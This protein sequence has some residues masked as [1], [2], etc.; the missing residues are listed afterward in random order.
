MQSPPVQDVTELLS[1]VQ[2]G[3][4]AAADVLMP[5]VY[6]ELRRLAQREL[7]A[8]LPGNTLQATALVHEAYLRLVDQ[9]RAVFRGRAQFFSIASMM[10]RR[11]LIDHARARRAQKRGGDAERITLHELSDLINPGATERIDLLALDE[12]M[13]ELAGLNHRQSRVVE[14]KFYGGMSIDEIAEVLD[15]SPRTV[16]D[17]WRFARAWLRSRLSELPPP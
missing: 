7:A 13:T 11:V 2:R 8:E 16:K 10:I 6:D 3:D 5:V 9:D 17:D 1:R 12:A 4:A 15:V 14:L